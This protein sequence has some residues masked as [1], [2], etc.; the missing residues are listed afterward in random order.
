MN[1]KRSSTRVHGPPGGFSQLSFGP[2]GFGTSAAPIPEE[3]SDPE[4]RD[5]TPNIQQQHQ[6]IP[7]KPGN[8]QPSMNQY[9]PP[10]NNNNQFNQGHP[11]AQQSWPQQQRPPPTSY[12]QAPSTAYSTGP[13]YPPTFS[14]PPQTASYGQPSGGLPTHNRPSTT[15]SGWGKLTQPPLTS[16]KRDQNWE[17]KRRQWL[18]RKNGSSR[19]N[20]TGGFTP[21][22]SNNGGDGGYHHDSPPSPLSKLMHNVNIGAGQEPQYHPQQPTTPCTQQSF[23]NMQ[24]MPPKTAYSNLPPRT[25]QSIQ[26]NSPYTPPSQA[27]YPRNTP[28]QAGEY[29]ARQTNVFLNS[30]STQFSSNPTPYPTSNRSGTN[31][32]ATAASS[33]TRHTRQ[34][35]GGTSN[36]SPYG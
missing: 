7:Q 6:F 15:G 31:T 22:Y 28:N 21:N 34:A 5:A 27:G 30:G 2:G 35:P 17:K 33:Y 24:N 36:W 25:Q 12:S 18:A 8:L 32:P 19:G 1:V 23:Q 13:S 11:Y 14:H 3:Q 4:L 10:N 20:S 26:M 16:S 29:S 9:R